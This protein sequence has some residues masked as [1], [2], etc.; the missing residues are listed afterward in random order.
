MV[1][2]CSSAKNT[3]GQSDTAQQHA[4]DSASETTDDTANGQDSASPPDCNGDAIEG[5]VTWT[6]FGEG[7]FRTYCNSCHAQSSTD[8]HGAPSYVTFDTLAQTRDHTDAIRRTV[9][10]NASMPVGGGVPADDLALLE[11]F[12]DGGLQP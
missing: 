8:R 10:E 4:Q 2:G 5:N 11:M 6:H 3:A 9:L 12:L 1:L 7:F